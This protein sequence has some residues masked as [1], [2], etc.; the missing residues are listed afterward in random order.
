VRV[1]LLEGSPE[2]T[3]PRFVEENG[4]DLVVLT[5]HGRTG[6]SQFVMGSTAQHLLP[7]LKSSVMALKPAEF[8]SPVE[9]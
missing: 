6:L 2:S 8:V 7:L 9:I 5:T 1:E 3:I 4:V